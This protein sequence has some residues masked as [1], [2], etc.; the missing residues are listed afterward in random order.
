MVKWVEYFTVV[1]DMIK[2]FFIIFFLFYISAPI[3]LAEEGIPCT[4]ICKNVSENIKK[5]DLKTIKVFLEKFS[6]PN[7]KN[8][9][10]YGEWSNE[11]IFILIEHHP[12]KFFHA[13]FNL[14]KDKMHSVIDEINCPIMDI[15]WRLIVDVIYKSD[16]SSHL[17]TEALK[18]IKISYDL[19]TDL[20]KVKVV[21]FE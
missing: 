10:E 16:L 3:S 7:C 4:A 19:D 17:K 20:G 2:C 21:E 5:V 1:S 11:L 15:N 8:N 14:P 13:L 18:L 6:D 12:N 9:V